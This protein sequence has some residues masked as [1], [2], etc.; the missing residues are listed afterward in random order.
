MP[1]IDQTRTGLEIGGRVILGV[2]G[3]LQGSSTAVDLPPGEK[4][5]P[6]RVA[7]SGGRQLRPD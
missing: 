7:G 2:T 4:A 6:V 3:V 5:L 1:I